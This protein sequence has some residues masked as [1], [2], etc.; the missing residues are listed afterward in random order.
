[1]WGAKYRVNQEGVNAVIV[2]TKKG[3]NC[4]EKLRLSCHLVDE[5]LSVVLEGQL[6]KNLSRPFIYSLIL[7]SLR[8]NMSLAMISRC[9]LMPYK[10]LLLPSRIMNKIYKMVGI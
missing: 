4:I 8:S 3:M 6:K 5:P 10:V 2:M 9:Y 7:K 1:M